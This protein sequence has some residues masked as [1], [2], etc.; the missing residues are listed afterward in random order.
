MKNMIKV[1]IF[2]L[3]GIFI[4]S[5][6]LSDRFQEK[7]GVSTEEFLVALKEIMAKVRKPDAGDAFNYWKLYLE[8]WGLR[9]TKEDFF[10][11]W[12]SGENEVLELIDLA[13]QIKNKGIKIFILSNNFVE[14]ADYYKQNFPFLEIFNKIYYSWQTGF[15]K[16][17]PMAFKNLLLENSLKPEE[18][19]YFDNSE[20]NIKAAN[21]L[22]IEAFL[23]K[24]TEGF[25]KILI[26]YQLI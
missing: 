8:K 24:D 16:P 18:C 6:K 22:G 3:N 21:S 5:P 7:F 25:K 4:Q 20:E 2:D 10:N 9:L 1:A 19:I 13:K 11:F 23:F 17:D 15:V 26:E 14:R 12:F